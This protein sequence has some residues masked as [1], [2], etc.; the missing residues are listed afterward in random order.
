MTRFCTLFSGSSGNAVY[1]STDQ[2]SILIDCGMSGRQTLDAMRQNGLSPEELKAILITHEHSDHV[3]GAG[4]LARR[5]GLPIYATEGTWTGMEAAVGDIPPQHRVV[6]TAGESFFLNDLEI[7]PFSI[8]HDANDPTG[9][10]I[11]TPRT[12]VA[13]ATDLGYFADSVRDAVTGA[14]VVLL[15]SNHDPDMLRQ[16]AFYPAQLKKRILGKK[17]HLSNESGAEAAVALAKSGTRHLL[18]GHLSSENNTPD[19]AYRTALSALENA[20]AQ[21]DRDVT[22]NVAGRFRTSCMYTMA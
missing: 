3:K 2:G 10:R 4:I 19:L 17:G 11:Y 8:P 14:E 6:I 15:E 21:L 9:Y 20:G 1:L 18:L 5:L 7:L 22:L 13:V 12:S 16:N